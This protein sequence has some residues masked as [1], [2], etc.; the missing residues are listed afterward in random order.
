MR[1]S[2]FQRYNRLHQYLNTQIGAQACCIT[3][4][5]HRRRP[6][7]QAPLHRQTRGAL[8]TGA[9]NPHPG[10]LPDP[11][12]LFGFGYHFFALHPPEIITCDGC[13]HLRQEFE[14]KWFVWVIQGH[15]RDR[16][17]FPDKTRAVGRVAEGASDGGVRA[18]RQTCW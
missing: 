11:I 8:I 18:R 7:A 10:K 4:F 1:K 17:A 13:M 3:L 6:V 5:A 16:A 14:R 2:N 12:K 15:V 9:S